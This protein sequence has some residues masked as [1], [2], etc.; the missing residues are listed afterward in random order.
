MEHKL[1][2]VTKSKQHYKDEWS[3]ALK[4]VASLKHR[5]QT[6]MRDQLKKQQLEL[7]AMRV[8]Y[9]R[10]EEQQSLQQQLQQ[11]KDETQRLVLYY[12]RKYYF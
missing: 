11:I 8:K 1:E 4:E 12:L 2:T 7:E 9:L 10:A 3:K 5:E 6:V